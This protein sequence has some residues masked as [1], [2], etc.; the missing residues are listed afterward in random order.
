MHLLHVHTNTLCTFSPVE[1]C[2]YGRKSVVL[3]NSI[4]LD[5]LNNFGV[6]H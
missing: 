5:N 6:L 2:I 4:L 3:I 1:I